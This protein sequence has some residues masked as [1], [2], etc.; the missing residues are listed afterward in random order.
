MNDIEMRSYLNSLSGD[1]Y[2]LGQRLKDMGADLPLIFVAV[3]LSRRIDSISR[4]PWAGWG[5]AIGGFVGGA[6]A[7]FFGMG[8]KS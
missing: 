4:P 1:E 2:D 6:I 5:H 3:T 8:G 7:A